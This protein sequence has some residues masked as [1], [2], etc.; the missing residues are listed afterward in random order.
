V[1]NLLKY[2]SAR[3]GEASSMAGYATIITAI[4][5]SDLPAWAQVVIAAFGFAA[6]LTRG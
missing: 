5:S 4:T 2:L 6:I 1:N 3:K